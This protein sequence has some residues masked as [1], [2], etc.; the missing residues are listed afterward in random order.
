MA[1]AHTCNV[2]IP[3][4]PRKSGIPQEVEMPAPVKTT[5]CLLCKHQTSLLKDT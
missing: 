3:L 5:R 1:L 2:Q 4:G